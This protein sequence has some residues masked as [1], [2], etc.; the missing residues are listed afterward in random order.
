M[1]APAVPSH[2]AGSPL[3]AERVLLAGGI[4][5]LTLLCWRYGLEHAGAAMVVHSPG[6]AAAIPMWAVMTCGMMLPAAAPMLLTYERVSARTPRGHRLRTLLFAGAYLALW[7][8]V[9]VAGA[10]AQAGLHALGLLSHL[11]ASTRPLLSGALLLA[12]GAYQLS[13]L[14]Q[15]C[16]HRCRTPMGF[17]LTEWEPGP[18][19]ALAMGLR[20]GLTCVLCCW[21]LMALMFVLGTMNLLW[22]GALA[23]LMLAEKALPA[24]RRLGLAAG[25][26]FVAWAGWVLATPG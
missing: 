6:L 22:M 8:G 16:L 25:W 18:R 23:A 7:V 1:S 20:H 19:G 5:M 26:A 12:A 21:A 3:R 17:V 14:K 4:V 15:V 9:S 24:G 11:G 10:A 2:V 13:P